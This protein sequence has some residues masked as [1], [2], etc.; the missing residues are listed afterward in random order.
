MKVTDPCTK[1]HSDTFTATKVPSTFPASH[2]WENDSTQSPSFPKAATP[3]TEEDDYTRRRLFNSHLFPVSPQNPTCSPKETSK[4]R[5]SQD[6]SVA[7]W[8]EL[9]Y[10]YEYQCENLRNTLKESPLSR[11]PDDPD[12]DKLFL[13]WQRECQ[14]WEARDR[15]L[16]T[17]LEKLSR[18]RE[19]LAQLERGT[20]VTPRKVNTKLVITKFTRKLALQEP[21]YLWFRV[22]KRELI[23][24]RAD[25]DL[26][27]R[28]LYHYVE[29][30]CFLPWSK[31]LKPE[32]MNDFNS[33]VTLLDSHFPDRSTPKERRNNFNSFQMKEEGVID[34]SEEKETLWRIAYPHRDPLEEPDYADSW[35]EGL[36][37]MIKDQMLAIQYELLMGDVPI[38]KMTEVAVG[39]E[40]ALLKNKA[41][42]Y[43]RS[44]KT[45]S[46]G[47]ENKSSD[48]EKRN[49]NGAKRRTTEEKSKEICRQH[50]MENGCPRGNNCP[51]KHTDSTKKEKETDDKAK[52]E[53]TEKESTPRTQYT[54]IC[55]GFTEGNCRYGDKCRFSHDT[56]DLKA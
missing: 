22:L 50:Q 15:L 11:P 40:R 29:S 47:Q 37:S 23:R 51:Y 4:G 2:P 5:P 1:P 14:V 28:T 17:T 3:D 52:T 44:F 33:V 55:R 49:F 12:D 54:T 16:N 35:L 56:K 46:S 32:V 45:V 8:H 19:H 38:T 27:L 42:E 39:V 18:A 34:Y 41:A 20:R 31:E 24:E 36:P 43:R 7:K 26:S 53:E 13:R 10:E 6:D 30:A 48:K 9:V 25:E 21:F